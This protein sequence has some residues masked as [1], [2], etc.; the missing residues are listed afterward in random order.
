[1]RDQPL[2]LRG[3]QTILLHFGINLLIGSALQSD[4]APETVLRH[5]A[6]SK[7]QRVGINLNHHAF[8]KVERFD[9]LGI[10]TSFFIDIA[11]LRQ[12]QHQVRNTDI[13]LIAGMPLQRV[14]EAV[15][16]PAA[17]PLLVQLAAAQFPVNLGFRHLVD[18]R[19]RRHIAAAFLRNRAGFLRHLAHRLHIGIDHRA[20]RT[21][22]ILEHAVNPD[23]RVLLLKF[24]QS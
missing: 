15:V 5:F 24:F 20:V 12:K 7:V 22:F 9:L 17:A 18:F 10:Q 3:Q 1:M 11:A 19:N 14:Q 23:L 21:E 2:V 4:D 8:R 13:K 16:T 6:R